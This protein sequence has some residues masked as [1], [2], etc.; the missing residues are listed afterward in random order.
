MNNFY[1]QTQHD[2]NISEEKHLSHN[3]LKIANLVTSLVNN[4]LRGRYSFEFEPY[5]PNG[6]NS[7]MWVVD[8]GNDWRISFSNENLK[9]ISIF[10][11]YNNK[12]AERAISEWVAYVLNGKV[13]EDLIKVK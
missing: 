7:T 5:Q 4:S 9:Y 3:R 1:I 2:I 11:R 6:I 8:S 10:H 13:V 12:I